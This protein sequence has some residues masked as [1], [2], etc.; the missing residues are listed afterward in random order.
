MNIKE[1]KLF[2]VQDLQNAINELADQAN[3]FLAR[4]NKAERLGGHIKISSKPGVLEVSLENINIIIDQGNEDGKSSPNTLTIDLRD[5]NIA[6]SFTN[7][8][9]RQQDNNHKKL[10]AFNFDILRCIAYKMEG[11]NFSETDI[12]VSLSLS[13]RELYKEGVVEPNDQIYF[14]TNKFGK[15]K[16]T[17]AELALQKHGWTTMII[18]NTIE[19]DLIIQHH[20]NKI[21][22]FFLSIIGNTINNSFVLDLYNGDKKNNDGYSLELAG[23]NKIKIIEIKSKK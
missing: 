23:G 16:I 9:I 11:C 12:N 13:Y 22:Q 5:K 20:S 1:G 8:N 15:L 19:K 18:D 7:V 2:T 17:Y 14:E 6:V 3:M 10:Q 4:G 21:K